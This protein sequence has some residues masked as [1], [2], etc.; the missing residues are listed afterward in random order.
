MRNNQPV[1]NVETPVPDGRFIYSRT[2]AHGQIL[3]AND[4]FVELSG[5]SREELIGQPHN[6]VRHPDM[7]SEAFADL[8]RNLKAGQ[9]W[10]GYVKNRRKDG[11]YYWV[12]AFA[13][14]V[15]ENG[16]VVGYESVRRRADPAV[17][18]KVDAA[19]RKLRG[20]AGLSVENGRV[21]GRGLR[22]SL[23]R[24][25]LGARFLAGMLA[26]LVLLLVAGTVAMLGL[27]DARD[28]LGAAAGET[29]ANR[30]AGV[31]IWLSCLLALVLVVMG[32]LQFGVVRRL[33]S[34]LKRFEDA[35]SATQR[36]GD[37][38]RV[39]DVDRRDELGRVVDAFN[40]MMANVQAIMIKI[41]GAAGE[42]CRQSDSLAHTSEQ[43]AHGASASS[44][45]ASSTTAAVEQVTVAINEVAE[46][47]R[48]AA[49]AARESSS[50]ADEGEGTAGRAA[51]EISRLAETT[52][53]TAATMEKL[54]RSSEDIG[55]IA[56]VIREIAEQTNLL[57]LN[58]A[59]EAA[60]AGEQ[61][62]GF[63]VVADEVRKLAER[64]SQATSE[65]SGIL[66]AL[67]EE[68]R[69]AVDGVRRG[70]DQVKSGVALAESA[71]GAL[72]SIRDATER[73]LLLVGDIA[74]A[75]N[76]Q[77]AA[78]T[79]ISQNI[80]SIAQM[81]EESAEAVASMADS[82]RALAGVSSALNEAISRV[83]I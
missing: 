14:P 56:T 76:E 44:E 21:V 13:S 12:R 82:S 27:D 83:Q 17:V 1:T 81:A 15:R 72:G 32:Y 47:A 66:D 75:T 64:T 8:W 4:L 79:S 29:E 20:G 73:C 63:A 50:R 35:V 77:S 59:I 34:D 49:E 31:A 7:P 42:V 46:H 74:N 67:R 5:F 24:M 25:S 71:R 65:I 30:I 11:G 45:A 36:D 22:G 19:Y 38:R 70:D 54:S 53:A 57:A 60:R 48:T 3:E 23:G 68:T 6:M 78:A 18:R 51:Q 62:R 43:V 10:N 2:D 69:R 58:A 80:E 37:L 55:R 28:A 40:A 61:G 16:Q 41:H 9:P 52:A 26:I 39:V 33:V